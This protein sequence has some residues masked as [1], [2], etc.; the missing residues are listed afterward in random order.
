M[1]W[2]FAVTRKLFTHKQASQF[3]RVLFVEDSDSD[4]A[5]VK[6]LLKLQND[7]YDYIVENAPSLFEALQKLDECMYDLV[8]LDLNL[9]DASGLEVISSLH[10]KA[11]DIPILVYSGVADQQWRE[12][13]TGRGAIG[14]LVKGCDEGASLGRVID[15]TI[16]RRFAA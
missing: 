9:L 16:T 1:A 10:V 12:R 2:D 15:E 8:L 4:I 5:Y 13:A 14:Y 6:H 11:P 7:K 3:A